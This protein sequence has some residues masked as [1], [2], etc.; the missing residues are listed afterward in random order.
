M[1]REHQEPESLIA[2]RT[3]LTVVTLAVA[4][5]RRRHGGTE[6]VERLCAH[7]EDALQHLIEDIAAVE[8]TLR[9]G[10]SPG[11]SRAPDARPGHSA[12]RTDRLG[13]GPLSL[14]SHRPQD[15]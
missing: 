7:A 8:A 13:T 12:T 6:D 4:Q 15:P 10:A 2:M 1:N 11:E 5:L 14:P 9:G 3:H